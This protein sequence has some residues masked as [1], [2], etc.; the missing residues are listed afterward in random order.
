MSD[1]RSPVKMGRRLCPC[2]VSGISAPAMPLSDRGRPIARLFQLLRQCRGKHGYPAGRR[3][4]RHRRASVFVDNGIVAQSPDT[5]P[6]VLSGKQAGAG[7]HTHRVVAH[8]DIEPHTLC[9]QSVNMGSMDNRIPIATQSKRAQLI[10]HADD[11]I[12][13]FTLLHR[14]SQL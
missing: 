8:G 11:D 12:A 14:R 2:A 10:A 7:R 3:I 9:S 6:A 13:F 5:R 4:F 1:C